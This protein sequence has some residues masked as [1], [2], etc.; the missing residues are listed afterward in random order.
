[1]VLVFLLF[2]DILHVFDESLLM[3]KTG[4]FTHLGNANVPETKLDETFVNK[5]HG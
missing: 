5:V 3:H 4:V 2:L 1:M